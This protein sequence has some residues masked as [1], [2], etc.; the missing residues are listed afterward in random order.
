MV[1]CLR[2]ARGGSYVG[3]MC[4]RDGVK[5]VFVFVE[6]S[7]PVNALTLW[8]SVALIIALLVSLR[9]RLPLK[10]WFQQH[11]FHSSDHGS[12]L[13]HAVSRLLLQCESHRLQYHLLKLSERRICMYFCGLFSYRHLDGLFPFLCRLPIFAGSVQV[14]L[15]IT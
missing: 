12:H 14:L 13:S 11:N 2:V 7:V 15:R 9:H 8:E 4:S 10:M 6:R 3:G 1:V 5:G